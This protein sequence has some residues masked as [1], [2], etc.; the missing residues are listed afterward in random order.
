M[1]ANATTC[2]DCAGAMATVRLAQTNLSPATETMRR[3]SSLKNALVFAKKQIGQ[4]THG[5]Q[6]GQ[7][8]DGIAVQPPNA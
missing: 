8:L 1:G 5:L 6:P 7:R 2:S 4:G 3:P